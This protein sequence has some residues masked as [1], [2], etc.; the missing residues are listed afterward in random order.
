V[1]RNPELLSKAAKVLIRGGKLG[2]R[3]E[4]G[5]EHHPQ[6][7]TQQGGKIRDIEKGGPYLLGG[8]NGDRLVQNRDGDQV[9][10][11]SAKTRD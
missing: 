9:G 5:W 3:G 6:E 2:I 1:G 4:V 7:K 8:K 11:N 10:R